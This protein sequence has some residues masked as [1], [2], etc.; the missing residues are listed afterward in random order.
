M[1]SNSW[2]AACHVGCQGLVSLLLSVPGIST[3]V[4]LGTSG[5]YTVS[6]IGSADTT[7]PCC[8]RYLL[9]SASISPM[10]ASVDTPKFSQSVST[11]NTGD[12]LVPWADQFTSVGVVTLALS[13]AS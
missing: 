7:F 13:A 9:V 6:W 1:L 2:K 4:R 5:E 12:V 10:I 3:N 8:C 11:T